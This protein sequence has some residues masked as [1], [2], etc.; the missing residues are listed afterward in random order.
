MNI[1]RT[2]SNFENNKR[3]EAKKEQKK[4]K[5]NVRIDPDSL[6]A[7]EIMYQTA[8]IHEILYE[9]RTLKEKMKEDSNLTEHQEEGRESDGRCKT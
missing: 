3:N 2:I 5:R 9:V 8:L 6:I 7:K 1:Y 4:F